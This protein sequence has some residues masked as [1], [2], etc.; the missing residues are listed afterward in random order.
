MFIGS[1]EGDHLS[2]EFR[3][4]TPDLLP[5][6][7][8]IPSTVNVSAGTFR[9]RAESG[10]HLS[11]FARFRHALASLANNP[12]GRASL[13]TEDGWLAVRLFGDGFGHFDARRELRDPDVVLHRLE[14]T[15]GINDRDLPSILAGLDTILAR[16]GSSSG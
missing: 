3:P 12:K 11:E 10:V 13:E 4:E 7:P 6:D 1:G 5:N 9:A 8:W 2:L 14:F 16:S 15:I